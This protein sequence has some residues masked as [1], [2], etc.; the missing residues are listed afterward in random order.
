MNRWQMLG[1]LLANLCGMTIVLIAVQFYTDVIPLFTK[2][3][4][5]IKPGQVVITKHVGTARTLSGEAP[6]F[7]QEEI[8][9]LQRQPFVNSVGPFTPSHYGV[10]ATIGSE[11]L[12]MEFSTDMF[13]E[14]IPDPY[15]DVDL[16]KWKYESGSNVVPIILPRNYLNLYNFGFAASKGMP[17]ISED[18]IKLIKIRLVLY[19]AKGNRQVNGRVVAFSKRLNTILVPQT[20]MDEMNSQLSPDSVMPPSRLVVQLGTITDDRFVKYLDDNNFETEADD[21]DAAR[22]VSFVRIIAVV[23]MVIGLI[24]SIL[25]FYLLLLSIFLLLQKHTEKIDNLLLIGSDRRDTSWDGN[26]DTMILMKS[27]VSWPEWVLDAVEVFNGAS[28]SNAKRLTAALDA[29]YVTLS[30]TYLG[31]SLMRCK[32]ESLSALDYKMRKEMQIE[33][34]EMHRKLGITFIFVTHDQ[35]EALTMSDKVVVMSDGDIQQVG[36]PEDIYNEPANLFV[37]D[38]IGASNIFKGK[39]VG[40]KQVEFCGSVFTCVDDYAVDTVIDAVVRPEDV[41]IMKIGSGQSAGETSEAK[42]GSAGGWQLSGEVLTCDFKGIFYVTAV[43]TDKAEI[44]IHNLKSFKAGDRV[45]LNI[46]PDNIHIIPYDTSIN[47]YEGVLEKY[48]AGK[49]FVI[50]QII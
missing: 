4:S 23:V 41:E 50:A 30:G 48:H 17:T 3:D 28:A 15:I 36:T 11:E 2:S 31:H 12:G 14:A 25:A 47:H 20:F 22:T 18:L 44:E 40:E 16:S 27:V 7:K 49:G 8:D 19:G 21:A 6:V 38:F 35:E 5:F 37:A 33:L 10:F 1:F 45:R 9:D 42:G 24:I 46:A 43:K 26:S 29:G 13:L 39:M 32:D 34:K